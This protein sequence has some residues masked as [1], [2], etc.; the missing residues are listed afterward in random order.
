MKPLLSSSSPSDLCSSASSSTKP[1]IPLIP[2]EV[3]LVHRCECLSFTIFTS[4]HTLT[5]GT[6]SVT[7]AFLTTLHGRALSHSFNQQ[8]IIQPLLCQPLVK[9]WEY[10]KGN[11]E[12]AYLMESS[13]VNKKKQINK[14]KKQCKH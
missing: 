7:S 10:C 8:T 9:G 12:G 5:W 3:P 14:K 13:Q 6:L 2:A 1:S 4:T 11:R